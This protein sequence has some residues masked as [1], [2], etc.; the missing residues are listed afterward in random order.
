MG[1]GRRYVLEAP[2]TLTALLIACGVVGALALFL[3]VRAAYTVVSALLDVDDE[4][5]R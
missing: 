4:V 3:L 2:R 1:L 5:N